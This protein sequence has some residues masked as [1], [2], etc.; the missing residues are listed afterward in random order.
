M[1]ADDVD[2]T[3]EVNSGVNHDNTLTIAELD[4]VSQ[5]SDVALTLQARQKVKWQIT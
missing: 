1:H 5:Q 3:W 2:L 4:Q